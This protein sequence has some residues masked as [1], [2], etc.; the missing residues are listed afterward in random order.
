MQ[1]LWQ[2]NT[3]L[4]QFPT[5]SGAIQTDVLVIGGGFA[6]LLTAWHLQQKGID[7]VVVEQNRI[8]QATTAHTTAKITA[9]HGLIYHKILNSRGAEQAAM[10]YDANSQ[11]VKALKELCKK[12]HCQL[13][14]KDN[15]VYSTRRAKLEAELSALEKLR[16]AAKYEDRLP[17]P[18]NATGAVGFSGQGQFHPLVL[19]QFLVRDL[20]VYENTKV[21]QMAGT[22]AITHRGKIHAKAV[23][24]ATHFPFINKHGSY[25]LKLYQ[26]RSYILAMKN[27]PAL[28]AMYVDDSDKGFSFSRFGD[29]FL[30]GGGGHRTGKQ[31]GSYAVLQQLQQQHYKTAQVCFSWGAQDTM[32]LDQ[33][34]YI[35]RY[36]RNTPNLYVATGFNKW[37]ITGSMVSALLLS[38]ILSGE[39]CDFAPVFSP[40]RSIL[41]PQLFLNGFETAKNLLMPTTPRCPHLGCA[42]HYNKAEHSWD[43]ACHGS[44]FSETGKVLDNPANGDLRK[45]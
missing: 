37:G 38:A 34:P 27:V 23:V 12:A 20:T 36:S 25:F 28:N 30:L 1:T 39:A 13:E 43:C 32:S 41:T 5:L 19:A 40:S 11:A 2:E 44:R 16:I 3:A 33:I 6:G 4:P 17:L 15:F 24:V 31:G 10:Y 45:R 9:Q 18:V 14:T 21:I 29:F 8:C 26:H 42:L 7:T 35:G 22:D